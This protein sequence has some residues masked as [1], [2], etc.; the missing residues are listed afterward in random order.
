MPVLQA[1]LSLDEGH[2]VLGMTKSFMKEAKIKFVKIDIT[3]EDASAI[4]SEAFPSSVWLSIDPKRDIYVWLKSKLPDSKRILMKVNMLGQYVLI[5]YLHEN[6][7]MFMHG[8]KS[9][10]ETEWLSRR[11]KQIWPYS[12][13]DSKQCKIFVINNN[14]YYFVKEI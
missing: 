6:M 14:N 1:P 5:Y 4:L 9:G 8:P 2:I 11:L 10:K 12:I 3:K 7:K 13:L